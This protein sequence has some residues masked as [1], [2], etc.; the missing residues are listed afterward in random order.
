VERWLRNLDH[1]LLL[2]KTPVQYPAPIIHIQ[3][4]TLAL[5]GS[6]TLFCHER[7][8]ALMSTYPHR[9]ITKNNTFLKKN[10][11]QKNSPSR[12]LKEHCPSSTP[13]IFVLSNICY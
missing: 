6:E 12:A 1:V 3:A 7:A 2:W 11:K 13:D 10:K 8:L 9:D 4:L 5:G